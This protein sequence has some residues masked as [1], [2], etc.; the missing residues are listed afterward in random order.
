MND[1]ERGREMGRYLD[2]QIGRQVE[3]THTDLE[4]QALLVQ[5]R[6]SLSF[7]LASSRLILSHKRKNILA[8]VTVQL[9]NDCAEYLVAAQG[10]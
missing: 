7:W 3:H 1:L 9:T 2:R 8:L 6:N 10:K 5:I 4:T